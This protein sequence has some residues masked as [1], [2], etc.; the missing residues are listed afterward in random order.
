MV[1]NTC[2]AQLEERMQNLQASHAALQE[3]SEQHGALLVEVLQRLNEMRDSQKEQE[4]S[5]GHSRGPGPFFGN[6]G[7]IHTR[8]MKLEFPRFNGKHLSGWLFKAKQYFAY[9]QEGEF[10]A[11]SMPIPSWLAKVREE[12][13]LDPYFKQLKDRMAEGLLDVRKY[14]FHNEDE[15]A[16]DDGAATS[17]ND[18]G[19][20]VLLR[21]REIYLFSGLRDLCCDDDDGRNP[22]KAGATVFI[23]V[24]L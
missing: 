13:Q 5:S 11:I 23:T 22:S 24:C 1:D 17:N 14:T 19:D 4:G 16:L 10:T 12:N 7:G 20:E 2:S 18:C 3:T 9:H 21:R 15:K 8:S 6:N